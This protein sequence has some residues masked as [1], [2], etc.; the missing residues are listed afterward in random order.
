VAGSKQVPFASLHADAESVA[1]AGLR[2]LER[3]KAI[4][5]P[6]LSN[7]FTAQSNRLLPRAL[8]RRIVA[9]LKL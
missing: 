4:V 3:N 7:K 5:I 1:A 8:M 2:G 9:S 6:G